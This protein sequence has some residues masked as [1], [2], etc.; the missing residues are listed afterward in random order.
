VI[1]ADA[2]ARLQQ[3][4]YRRAGPGLASS[5]PPAS[6][7]TAAQL[8]SFLEERHYCVLATTDPHGHAIA[9]PVAFTVLRASF[10]FATV[11]GARLRNLTRTPWAS[12]AIEDGEHGDHRAVVADGVVRI[13]Q[14]PAAELLDAWRE[15]HGSGADWAAAWCEL[16]PK[17]L[18][19]YTARSEDSK[20]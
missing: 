17:R 5:W 12:A 6:A 4:S 14:G 16:T 9:R 18:L 3:D 19:S 13:G 8:R 15:R 11:A 1:D 10:W 2:L 7:M 20:P